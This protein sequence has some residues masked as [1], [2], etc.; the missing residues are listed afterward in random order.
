MNALQAGR[1][2]LAVIVVATLTLLGGWEASQGIAQLT[3]PAW[4]D[5]KEFDHF[6]CYEVT[7]DRD[8]DDKDKD[9][10]DKGAITIEN[11][12]EHRWVKVGKLKLL[13]VPTKKEHHDR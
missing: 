8:R 3:P 5:D 6:A 9:D 10:E 1:L 2:Q 7:H 4:A 13:C 12:F 11:Q